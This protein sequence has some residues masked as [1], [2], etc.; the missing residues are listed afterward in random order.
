M[1]GSLQ[2]LEAPEGVLAYGRFT[3]EE[4]VLIL[5]NGGNEAQLVNVPVWEIGV[6]ENEI[7]EQILF[8]DENG[9]SLEK[10]TFPVNN[11][12]LELAIPGI[13]GVILK[14]ALHPEEQEA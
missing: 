13:S 5:I 10:R 8:N 6:G 1:H 4:K 12:L 11:G 2:M 3:D 9:Y 7:M 14:A